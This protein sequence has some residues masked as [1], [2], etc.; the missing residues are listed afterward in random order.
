M[1]TF[2]YLLMHKNLHGILWNYV[3][4]AASSIVSKLIPAIKY[5]LE[6]TFLKIQRVLVPGS[7]TQKAI[8]VKP[9]WKVFFIPKWLVF[10]VRFTT[11][12]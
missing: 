4:I 3:S 10:V 12:Y 1:D 6:V 8:T 5:V 9:Q 11:K 2:Q 7:E